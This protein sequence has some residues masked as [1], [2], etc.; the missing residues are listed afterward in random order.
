MLNSDGA[1]AQRARLRLPLRQ[2]LGEGM[3][4]AAKYFFWSFA[5]SSVWIGVGLFKN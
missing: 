1:G 3:P 2:G 5:A 4:I